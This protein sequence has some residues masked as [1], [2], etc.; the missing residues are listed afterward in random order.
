MQGFLPFLYG[1]DRAPPRN[2]STFGFAVQGVL[3]T[4]VMVDGRLCRS[5]QMGA[6]KRAIYTDDEAA[7]PSLRWGGRSPRDAPGPDAV[8]MVESSTGSWQ[9]AQSSGPAMS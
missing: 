6:A 2:F 3:V 7:L 5:N 4:A 9:W 1:T 8:A